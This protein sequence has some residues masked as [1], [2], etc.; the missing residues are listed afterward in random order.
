MWVKIIRSDGVILHNDIPDKYISILEE[1][2]HENSQTFLMNNVKLRHGK[3]ITEYGSVYGIT[4]DAYI[5]NRPR[6]FRE[7]INAYIRLIPTIS[8][9]V[10]E[11]QDNANTFVTRLIHNLQ[12]LNG[13]NIQELYDLISEEEFRETT[14]E[15]RKSLILH[16]LDLQRDKIHFTIQ[17]LVKNNTA[18]KIQFSIF[19]KIFSGRNEKLNKQVHELRKA[20]LN[21]AHNFFQ[22]FFNK[23]IKLMIDQYSGKVYMDYEAFLVSVYQLL[24]NIEKYAM[25][26]SDV[27]I[28][29][30]EIGK[31]VEIRM[32][33]ISV[34][35]H[36]HELGNI[37]KEY[38]RGVEAKKLTESGEG[39]GMY[40]IQKTLQQNNSKLIVEN[41]LENISVSSNGVTYEKNRFTVKIPLLETR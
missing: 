5:I 14:A 27:N 24:E 4:D 28:S 15:Q 7:I 12:S 10:K 36:D 20:F 17:N 30:I 39:I 1:T 37:S 23:N 11:S 19:K 2:S 26:D 9:A 38:Y 22:S 16:R 40:I 13:Q 6:F 35:I 3:I 25:K 32:E 33:M 34:K 29:F 21:V 8:R 31:H 41:N 18:T